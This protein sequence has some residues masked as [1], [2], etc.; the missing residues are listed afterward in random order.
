MAQTPMISYGIILF[1][2]TKN[3]ILMVQSASTFPMSCLIG[4]RKYYRIKDVLDPSFADAMSLSE[5]KECIS[6]TAANGYPIFLKSVH[7]CYR[8]KMQGMNS[9]E[10]DR[11]VDYLLN[12]YEITMSYLRKI[13]VKSTTDGALPWSFP[14]GRCKKG[15]RKKDQTLK[16]FEISVALREFMEET[17]APED[18]IKIHD[19]ITP[20]IVQYHD[21]GVCYKFVFYYATP[22]DN[23]SYHID[24]NDIDQ[25]NEIGAIEWL[26]YSQLAAKELCSI[27]RKHILN[28]Y[29]D[30]LNHF[31]QNRK[32]ERSLVTPVKLEPRDISIIVQ[33]PRKTSLTV[34]KKKSAP[35][36]SASQNSYIL[37]MSNT[38]IN[39]VQPK[40]YAPPFPPYQS[41][42]IILPDILPFS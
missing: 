11:Y 35:C 38:A 34:T 31:V 6:D 10:C 23:F 8:Q 41:K 14:K 21:M 37:N 39:S 32:I 30:I 20:F 16:E 15:E 29:A 9:E 5:K 7:K 4:G 17:K 2:E 12:D 1:D 22:N 28:N 36:I 24:L 33:Q 18:S 40:K 42:V 19:Y 3:A 27:T 26:S 25:I 13:I